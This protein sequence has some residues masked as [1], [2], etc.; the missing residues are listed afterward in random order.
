[1]SE[2]EGIDFQRIEQFLDQARNAKP[3]PTWSVA[4]TATPPERTRGVPRARLDNTFENFNLTLNPGMSEAFARCK[5]VAER[6]EWCAMLAGSYGNGKTHLA[7]AAMNLFG[8]NNSYFWKVPD[9]LDFL[10]RKAFD[11]GMALED[12]T[13]SYRERPFL[14]VLDDLGVE[15]PTDW[16]HEQIYKILDARS[17]LRLPTILTTNV[18]RGRLDGRIVSRYSGGLVVCKGEDLRRQGY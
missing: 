3:D 4:G 7:L 2:N 5:A 18:D 13:R 14:L 9:Y 17:D 16:A 12:V 1:M 10:K 6:E 8:I 15:N 11:E